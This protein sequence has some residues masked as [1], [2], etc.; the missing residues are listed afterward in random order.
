MRKEQGIT[1]VSLVVTIIVL[2]ILAG[3]SINLI[4][5]EN[6]IITIAKQAKENIELSKIEEETALNELYTQMESDGENSGLNYDAITL[7]REFRKKIALAITN[8]GVETLETDTAD[9][10]A[11]NIGKI[12]DNISQE[13]ATATE[14]KILKDY[15]AYKDGKLIT[16]TMEN[17]GAISTT[18]NAGESYTIPVGYHNGS[19][20]ITANSLESQTQATATADNITEG[21]T[22][23]V[24]GELIE[25][26]KEENIN[27]LSFIT[28]YIKYYPTKSVS[29]SITISNAMSYSKIFA[30]SIFN[31]DSNAITTDNFTINVGTI[32]NS[33]NNIIGGNLYIKTLWITP[34]DNSITF[35]RVLKKTN[36][37]N[38]PGIM[39]IY[40]A[41][42]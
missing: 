6:G 11:D 12:K 22:A 14:D 40:G 28:A 38:N 15:T 29:Q 27:N 10:M 18:L 42:K 7:L 4:L 31:T 19:G 30:V 1:L 26:I 5:G 41:E 17:N 34:T 39:L 23:W 35:S 32:D 2:I 8:E 21:K 33:Q 36:G 9:T 16:G 20:K 37:Y 13:G 3:V 25:G 24:N